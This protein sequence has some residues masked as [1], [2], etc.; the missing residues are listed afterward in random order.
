MK[1]TVTKAIYKAFQVLCIEET[2]SKGSFL[3]S[4]VQRTASFVLLDVVS[5]FPF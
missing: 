2:S 5:L 3:Q 4:S 1:P